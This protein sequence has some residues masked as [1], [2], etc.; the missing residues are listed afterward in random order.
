MAG[1]CFWAADGLY[2]SQHACWNSVTDPISPLTLYVTQI[3]VT[4]PV[5][6]TFLLLLCPALLSCTQHATRRVVASALPRTVVFSQP[7]R[8]VVK[9]G[10]GSPRAVLQQEIIISETGKKA[11]GPW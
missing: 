3:Y 8:R 11:V 10:A 7:R 4:V 5:F 1:A 9:P 2:C 6:D